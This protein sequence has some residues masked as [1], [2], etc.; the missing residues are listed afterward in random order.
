MIVWASCVCVALCAEW[1]QIR[2]CEF[3]LSFVLF[4]SPV[5]RILLWSDVALWFTYRICPFGVWFFSL[6]VGTCGGSAA[7]NLHQTYEAMNGRY[8]HWASLV[9]GI[10]GVVRCVDTCH[11]TATWNFVFGLGFMF[12]LKLVRKFGR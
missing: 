8:W 4:R 6:E 11:A 9:S 12:C 1:L 10:V 3:K 5:F 7:C 2:V